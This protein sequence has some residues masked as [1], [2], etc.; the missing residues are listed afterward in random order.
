MVDSC[1]VLL[2]FLHIEALTEIETPLDIAP[3]GTIH[4]AFHLKSTKIMAVKDTRFS[5][6][7]VGTCVVFTFRA[8][9][10]LNEIHLQRVFFDRDW[11][12]TR[13]FFLEAQRIAFGFGVLLQEK[14]GRA[15]VDIEGVEYPF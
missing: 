12:E 10:L 14:T 1:K 4:I 15:L 13:F 11:N 8:H 2:G 3:A 5:G 7:H 6:P 9:I